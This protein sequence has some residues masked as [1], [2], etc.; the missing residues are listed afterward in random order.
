MEACLNMAMM[1]VVD[2]NCGGN[3]IDAGAPLIVVAK[4][5]AHLSKARAVAKRLDAPWRVGAVDSEAGR[6][7]LIVDAAGLRLMQGDG[8]EV[9]VD[10]AALGKPRHGHDL[11]GRAIGRRDATVVDATAGL[12]ADAFQLA[13][14]GHQVTMVERMPL[15]ALLLEDALE[16]ARSGM[17]GSLAA[18]ASERLALVSG[19]ARLYLRQLPAASAPEVILL[20]PMY[21]RRGKAALPAKG[22]ALFRRLVGEDDDADELL[23]VARAVALRRVVVKRPLRAPPLGG[24][25]PSGSLKGSTTRYDLY[26]PVPAPSKLG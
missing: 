6:L 19:D 2:T 17:V 16:R 3:S 22:M 5:E 15:V 23:T 13:T 8:S 18:A 11:L 14:A 1:D 10:A 25:M 26:A 12:G 4:D 21:P 7:L 20:D 24:M 9:S